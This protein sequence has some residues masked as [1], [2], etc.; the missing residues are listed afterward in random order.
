V[1]YKIEIAGGS[2]IVISAADVEKITKEPVRGAGRSTR[3]DLPDDEKGYYRSPRRG[4]A[5]TEFIYRD[6]GYFFQGQ[7]VAGFFEMGTRVVNGYKFNQYAYLGLG[8]GIDGVTAPVNGGGGNSGSFPLPNLNYDFSGA[9]IPLF[10]YYAGDILKRKIT[11]FYSVE[12]GYAFRPGN[13]ALGNEYQT[14]C[15]GGV[16]A[17]VGIGARIF[18]RGRTNICLSLNLDMKDASNKYTYIAYNAQGNPYSYTST[19]TLFML[20]PSFKLGIGF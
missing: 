2:V 3:S 8:I 4:R 15:T 14:S 16:M 6:K 17:A 19:E 7:V 20:M 11:P 1:S 13:N 12:L 18:K 10:I 9:Y 5:Q